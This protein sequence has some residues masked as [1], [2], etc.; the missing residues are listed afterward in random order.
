MVETMGEGG[1]ASPLA[2]L[3]DGIPPCFSFLRGARLSK[4]RTSLNLERLTAPLELRKSASRLSYTST[5]KLE[6]MSLFRGAFFCMNFI[7]LVFGIDFGASR[8][9][10]FHQ[11]LYSITFQVEYKTRR[12]C[13]HLNIIVLLQE[14][15]QLRIVS[16]DIDLLEQVMIQP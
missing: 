7:G 5:G 6:S 1:G 14:H 8:S 2:F 12:Q 10:S 13:V 9:S 4:T 3:F 11:G 15:H 16:R